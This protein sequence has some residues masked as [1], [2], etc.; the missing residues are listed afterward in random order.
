MIDYTQLTQEQFEQ[1]CAALYAE[2]DRRS[3]LGS[4][5]HDIQQLAQDFEDLGGKR[6]DLVT[7]VNEPIAVAEVT[8]IVYDETTPEVIIGE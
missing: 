4:I 5:P 1:H 7:K 8:P 6:E 2:Q 3:K